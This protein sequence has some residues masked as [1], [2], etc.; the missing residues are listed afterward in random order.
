MQPGH[1][2]DKNGRIERGRGPWLTCEARTPNLTPPTCIAVHGLDNSRLV[3]QVIAGP[4]GSCGTRV[5]N[6]CGFVGDRPDI[7]VHQYGPMPLEQNPNRQCPTM[8]LTL[9]QAARALPVAS[10]PS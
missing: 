2:N 1:P 5:A 7:D 10:G 9:V 8:P 3:S 4:G 6:P